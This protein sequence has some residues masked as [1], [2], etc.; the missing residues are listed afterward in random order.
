[1]TNV[2]IPCSASP[3]KNDRKAI[4]G[5][6]FSTW[7]SCTFEA[8]PKPLVSSFIIA[9]PKGSAGTSRLLSSGFVEKEPAWRLWR[10]NLRGD[11][12]EGTFVEIVEEEP[13]GTEGMKVDG[14]REDDGAR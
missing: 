1:M 12:G 3:T 4:V 10:R 13:L 5:A 7:E 2:C 9:A 14:G 11:C 6:L 8:M